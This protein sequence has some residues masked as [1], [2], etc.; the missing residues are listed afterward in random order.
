MEKKAKDRRFRSSLTK[1]EQQ[2]QRSDNNNDPKSQSMYQGKQKEDV[3]V[4]L[5][6]AIQL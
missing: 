5:M 3:E 1:Q 4:R 2:Q 6:T